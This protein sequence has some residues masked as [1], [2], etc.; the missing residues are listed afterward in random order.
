MSRKTYVG[1]NQTQGLTLIQRVHRADSFVSRLRGLTFRRQLG[2]GEGL[3]L[4]GRR[5]SRADAAIH[6]FFVF[7]PIGVLWLDAQDC[8]VDKVVAHPFR[9][10]YVP[11]FP[12]KS[13][14]ECRPE[15]VE[16]VNIGDRLR[17]VSQENVD[18]T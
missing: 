16:R 4:V 15:V 10:F 17:L 11:R 13:V 14:L 2:A 18:E 6:M 5:E 12:A 8:V 7:F 9:P 3:L 1:E